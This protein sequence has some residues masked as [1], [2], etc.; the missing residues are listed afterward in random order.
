M[1][2]N[3]VKVEKSFHRQPANEPASVERVVAMLADLQSAVQE[4]QAHLAGATKSH[5]TVE[6]VAEK[7]GRAPYTVRSWIKARRIRADRV[8]GTGP[9]GRLLVP[10]EELT[11]LIGLGLGGRIPVIDG[12]EPD[13][14]Q[15][16]ADQHVVGGTGQ[17]TLRGA[18]ASTRTT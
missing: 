18:S 17:H 3:Q 10:R 2:M 4:I 5:Y 11:R 15:W 6:E 7:T 16:G 14:A 12:A 1:Q 9:R 13:A 8:T